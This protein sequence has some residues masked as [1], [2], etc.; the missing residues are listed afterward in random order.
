MND[1]IEQMND[2]QIID[3]LRECI[4]DNFPRARHQEYGIDD[5][6]FDKGIVDSLGFLTLIGFIEQT[7]G[8]SVADEDVVP[9]NFASLRSMAEY[10]ESRTE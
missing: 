7:Y 1:L 10:I 4:E 5:D 2:T 6:L 3:E 8:I 9:E